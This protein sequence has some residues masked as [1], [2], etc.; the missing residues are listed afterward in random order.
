MVEVIN[1]KIGQIFFYMRNTPSIDFSNNW[2][3]F[4]CQGGTNYLQTRIKS[5]HNEGISHHDFTLVVCRTKHWMLILSSQSEN[6]SPVIYHVCRH[7]LEAPF[8][9]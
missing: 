8:A 5:L 9:I 6:L 4:Q 2:Y 3:Q 7:T 1:W